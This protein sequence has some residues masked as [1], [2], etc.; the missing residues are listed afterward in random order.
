ME[1][2]AE[3]AGGLAWRLWA[4]VP[5]V[6][7][8]LAVTLVVSFGD[9]VV[10]LVGGSPPP[11]DAFDVRRVELRSGEIRVLARWSIEQSWQGLWP[12]ARRSEPGR[13]ICIRFLCNR[14]TSTDQWP[15]WAWDEH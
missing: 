2:R 8:A 13:V 4:L 7:L 11:A 3:P 15:P 10:D 14:L 6:G 5:L 9:R 1:S 12:T